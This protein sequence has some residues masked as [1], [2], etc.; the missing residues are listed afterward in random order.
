MGQSH[1]VEEE[2]LERIVSYADISSEDIVLEVGPGIGN[3]TELLV[4][5]AGKVI[6]VEKDDRLVEVLLDRLGDV[7]NLSL[8]HKDILDTELPKFNKAVANLPYSISSPFTFKL[9][10]SE[11][12][13]GV[14]TYQREFAWRMV[15]SP[16]TQNYSHLSVNLS[17]R[18]QVELLEEIPPDAFI[19][20]P[21]VWSAIVKIRSQEPAFEV[22]NEEL[23]FR[24]VRAAF[25]HRRQKVRNSLF[26][27]FEEIVPGSGL[28]KRQKRNFIDEAISEELANS[29]ADDISPEEFGKIANNLHRKVSRISEK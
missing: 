20:Q 8:V 5:D 16:S 2:I 27:S 4:E 15:A 10:E 18:A 9:I 24:T 14:F 22:H 6:A 13:L 28:S 21:E 11:F 1:L 12:D 25:Q 26:H 23:F 17:Y 7:E 19:P 3:L 29:R